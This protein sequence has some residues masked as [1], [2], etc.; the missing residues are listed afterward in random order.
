[1]R[2]IAGSLLQEMTGAAQ[3]ACPREEPRGVVPGVCSVRSVWGCDSRG[4]LSPLQSVS[5]LH[6]MSTVKHQ[7]HNITSFPLPTEHP[8]HCPFST[9]HLL[10]LLSHWCDSWKGSSRGS[11]TLDSSRKYPCGN[12]CHPHPWPSHREE[13]SCKACFRCCVSL[14]IRLKSPGIWTCYLAGQCHM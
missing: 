2:I 4:L 10:L 11:P 8:Y 5:L 13:N 3:S 6:F 7:I 1:M 12:P 9:V 14:Y